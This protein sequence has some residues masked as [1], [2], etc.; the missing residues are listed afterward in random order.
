[1]GQRAVAWVIDDAPV[2]AELAWTLV[3]I[4]RRCDDNGRGSYQST[5]TI[6]EKTGKSAKQAQRDVAKLRE[7]GLIVPGD[8]SLVAHLPIGQRP[9]VYN[10]PLHLKGPKPAKESRN[11]SGLK[12]EPDATTPMEGTPPMQGTPPMDGEWTPPMDAPGTP[13]MQ[14]NQRT[15]MNNP[16]EE[17]SGV[18]CARSGRFAPSIGDEDDDQP[19]ILGQTPARKTRWTNWREEDLELLTSLVGSDKVISDGSRSPAGV[20]TLRKVYESLE[21][22]PGSPKEWPGRWAQ[23]V[24]ETT[25]IVAW[26]A[27][28]GLEPA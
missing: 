22:F 12:K 28:H 18:E 13:P 24:E 5:G 25:G 16:I 11:K 26:L 14:G 9:V 1:V 23:T 10:L 7:L 2:P 8:Q 15:P 6:A 4:A 27:G 3:V 17:R 20:Y 21:V 19:L